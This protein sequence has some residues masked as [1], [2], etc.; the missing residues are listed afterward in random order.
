MKTNNYYIAA[1]KLLIAQLNV[2]AIAKD[3]IYLQSKLLSDK[4]EAFYDTLPSAYTFMRCAVE[5][6]F[7]EEL[8]RLST[9][10]RKLNEAFNAAEFLIKNPETAEPNYDGYPC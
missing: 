3:E 6:E 7:D 2:L 8:A 5:T 10:G 1:E 9:I 4:R